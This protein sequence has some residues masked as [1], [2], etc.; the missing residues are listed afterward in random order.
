MTRARS[1]VHDVGASFV[2]FL[3]A[4][5]LSMGIALASGAPVV[6]G[7]I[8][9]AIGG[10]V[11]GSL[12]GV[13]LQVSGPAAGLA[14]MVFDDMARFGAAELGAIIVVAGA[15]Q[16]ALG[17]ARIARLAMAISPAV[18]H[19]MLA[20]I[21]IQIALAQLHVVLGG[22][23]QGSALGNI[24][25]L[26]AQLSALHGPATVLGLASI[27]IIVLWPRLPVKALRA[28]PAPLVA[29]AG[30]TAAAVLLGLQAPSV[31]VPAQVGAAL[32]IP[33]LP[34]DLGAAAVAAVTLAIVASAESLLCAVATDKL[35]AGPRARLDRELVAQGVGNVLS[36]LIGGLP[37][38]G[39]IVRSRANIDA[40]AR[41]RLSGVLHG[42]WIV[43]FVSFLGGV[44]V[45]IPK[46]ALA[47]L[48]VV[49][50]IRLVSP[51]H[52]REMIATRQWP[53][54][55][56]TVAGVIGIN[57]LAGIALGVGVAVVVLLR[58][59]TRVDVAV[60]RRGNAWRIVAR[61]ALTFVGVPRLTAALARVPSGHRVDVDLDVG[62]MDHAA[63]EA[64]HAWRIGYER[65]GGQVDMDQVH[66]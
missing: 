63:L 21:G 41:S 64:L 13:P 31:E 35:H 29:V 38:T 39:V 46:A 36:G 17:S 57:L 52:I 23:P 32:S 33:T 42:L 16:I 10:L 8:A 20:G 40:G 51:S 25:A 37:I 34:H 28:V 24:A 43:L 53:V 26:P 7:L 27:G 44:L 61:G 19:G 45:L 11:V 60:E 2:V 3:V 22:G 56:T 12:A 55:L 14:V 54:Y 50:G 48:L 66:A 5:P 4:L 59:L 47:G 58:R 15:L 65:M 1:I 62:V 18:I 30:L 9:A 6:S 49:V